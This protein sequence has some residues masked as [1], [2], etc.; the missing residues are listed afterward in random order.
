MIIDG[1]A[2][3]P[4]KTRRSA[5]IHRGD[6]HQTPPSAGPESGTTQLRL[7]ARTAGRVPLGHPDHRPPVRTVGP[8]AARAALLAH[9][10]PQLGA[11]HGQGG[12]VIPSHLARL[13]L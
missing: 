10:E 1:A 3:A 13:G 7:L 6:E 12:V 9:P 5:V 4:A 8:L 2:S 11:V